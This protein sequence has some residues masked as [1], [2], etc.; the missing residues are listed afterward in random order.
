MPFTV[1]APVFAV[2]LSIIVL[3]EVMSDRMVAGGLL[4]FAGVSV[5]TFRNKQEIDK[6]APGS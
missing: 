6:L 4:A 5:I 2:I 3:G 1:L